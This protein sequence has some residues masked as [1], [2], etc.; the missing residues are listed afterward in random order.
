VLI[1]EPVQKLGCSADLI[2]VKLKNAARL[3][4][5]IHHDVKYLRVGQ[6]V[7]LKIKFHAGLLGHTV[8]TKCEVTHLG[9]R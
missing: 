5:N 2:E 6:T 4:E 8:R 9:L 3:Y 7:T 1:Q